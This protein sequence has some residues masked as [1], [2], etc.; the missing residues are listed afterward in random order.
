MTMK[1]GW[2]SQLVQNHSSTD[3]LAVDLLTLTAVGLQ[4]LLANGTVT[5]V[6]AVNAYL[7]HI[8]QHNHS[9]MQLNAL[10]SIAD[11][12]SL[13]ARAELLDN[14]RQQGKLRSPFHGVPLIVKVN[15]L[16]VKSLQNLDV[17]TNKGKD[18]C[19]TVDLPST[20]GSFALKQGQA[21]EDAPIIGT[22]TK[23]GL[24]ILGKSNLSASTSGPS[25]CCFSTA[26]FS[27]TTSIAGIW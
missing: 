27:L 18:L 23:A 25:G 19:L 26:P 9:G 14:E 21:K 24:I 4:R 15:G 22:L 10:I 5:S 16:P 17:V 11:R 20:C 2:L 6:D 3:I 13:V 12:A 7:D 8:A 1:R